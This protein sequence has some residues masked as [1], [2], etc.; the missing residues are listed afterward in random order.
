[1]NYHL[2]GK[3]SP[4]SGPVCDFVSVRAGD[5]MFHCQDNH[6]DLNA[7]LRTHSGGTD[8]Y[9]PLCCGTTVSAFLSSSTGMSHRFAGVA[10]F[11]SPKGSTDMISIAT[12]GVWNLELAARTGVTSGRLCKGMPGSWSEYS[13]VTNSFTVSPGG[14]GVSIG[15]IM[16]TKAAAKY[17][18][19]KLQT[20]YGDGMAQYL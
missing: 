6:L 1:M 14:G 20:I 10:L 13:H 12:R 15:W 9:Y 8:F 16:K 7:N 17:A 3:Q 18:S 2:S 11:H 4:I 19:V 5:L